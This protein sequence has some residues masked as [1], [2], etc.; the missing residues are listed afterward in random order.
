MEMTVPTPSSKTRDTPSNSAYHRSPAETPLAGIL[1]SGS[2]KLRFSELKQVRIHEGINETR[3][4]NDDDS[5]F[6]TTIDPQP[7]KTKG[8]SI[9]EQEKLKIWGRK[10]LS[11]YSKL[12]SVS[13][14]ME[15]FRNN[16]NLEAEFPGR[17]LR[18]LVKKARSLL[19]LP[20]INE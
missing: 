1:N 20:E 7:K 5:E 19:E 16:A 12:D 15:L 13:F 10:T 6:D 14:A 2:R 3:S 11:N 9:E 17:G 4:A 8:Y 18:F